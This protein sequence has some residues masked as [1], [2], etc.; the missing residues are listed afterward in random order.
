MFPSIGLTFPRYDETLELAIIMAS[1]GP[2]IGHELS[3]GFDPSGS[4]FGALGN[5]Q[6]VWQKESIGEFK[7]SSE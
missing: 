6:R 1:L 3:H 5:V 4:E 7:V 2:T